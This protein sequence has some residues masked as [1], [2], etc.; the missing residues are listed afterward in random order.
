VLPRYCSGHTSATLYRI[1]ELTPFLVGDMC[2][3]AQYVVRVVG[4][5]Q[6]LLSTHLR[7]PVQNTGLNIIPS[8]R[9]VYYCSVCGGS[10]SAKGIK[11]SAILL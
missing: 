8:V 7:H 4:V 5:A 1:Q 10:L 2:G 11:R 6:V 9:Y 3:I